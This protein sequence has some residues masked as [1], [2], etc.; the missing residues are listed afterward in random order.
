MKNFRSVFIVFALACF[1][2]L[3]PAA[4]TVVESNSAHAAAGTNGCT[5]SG[6]TV[7]TPSVI[8]CAAA[9]NLA[10]GNQVQIT[11]IVGTTTDNVTAFV[12]VLSSTTFALY[13][14]SGLATGITGTGTYSSG[15]VVTEATD[16]SGLSGDN[17]IRLAISSLTS[18]A[19]VLISIQDS[20]DGF[21]SDIKTLAV[22]NVTG[23]IT[24]GT[25]QTYVFRQYSLPSARLGVT[26]G[27][28][29]LYVQSISGS[30]SVTTTLTI[31]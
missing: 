18:A 15:G 2:A 17:T 19:N 13:S 11:G 28:L 10:S 5:V 31:N 29:R 1:A 27:R 21:V 12:N 3:M 25:P 6:A 14:D 9:H 22:V 8:T 20:A 30:S 23:A 24:S 7:A 4:T 16:I 26:N